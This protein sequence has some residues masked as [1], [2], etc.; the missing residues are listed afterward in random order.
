MALLAADLSAGSTVFY[1]FG[2]TEQQQIL[3]SLPDF[4]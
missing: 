3:E 1:G 4:G 2:D